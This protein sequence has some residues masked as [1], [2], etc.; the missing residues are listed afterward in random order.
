VRRLS[1]IFIS[2][3]VAIS[4]L[5]FTST[6]ASAAGGTVSVKRSTTVAPA[7]VPN[8]TV[9]R[10]T[11]LA[12]ANSFLAIGYDSQA[13]GAR[14]H[15][16]KIKEDMTLD[17]SFGAVNFGADLALPTA[18]NS[19]CVS[20]NFNS[21]WYLNSVSVNETT[22]RYFFSFNRDVNSSANSM[23]NARLTT[24]VVGKLSTG[25]VIA[26]VTNLEDYGNAYNV[27]DWSAYGATK[28]ANNTCTSLWGA[29]FQSVPLSAAQLE[30]YSALIRS[31]GSAV[32]NLS[33]TYSNMNGSNSS[34]HVKEYRNQALIAVKTSG[35]TLVLDSS[36]GTNGALKLFDDPTKCSDF[37]PA[38]TPDTSITSNSSSKLFATIQ[39]ATG[40]RSNTYQGGG[41][42]PASYDGCGYGMLTNSTTKL[43]AFKADGAVIATT[44][45]NL[46]SSG[47]YINR[48]I[49]DPKGNWNTV[50]RTGMGQS[51]STK[52]LR[53]TPKGELDTTLG[54]DGT[55]TL[56]GL[57]ATISVNGTNVNMFYSISGIAITSNGFYF[58]GFSS[59]GSSGCNN[60]NYTSKTYPYY[61]SPESGL[62]TSYGTNGLGEGLTL[63]LSNTTNCSGSARL[64]YINSKGQHGTVA[65]VPAIGS[66]VAGLVGATWDATS[67]V[68]S[69]GEGS[70][71][72]GAAG[73]VDKKVYSTRLPAATQVDSALTVLTAKQAQDLDIR[74]NTPRI[75]VALTTSVLM[76]NPGRCS[77]RIID[78]DTKKVIRTMTTIVKKSDVAEGTT[79]TTDEPIYFRQANVRLSKNA[80]A[81]VAELAAAAKDAKRVVV[82]G[83]SAALGDVSKYSFA[84]SRNRANAVKAAL[85][86]AGVKA[87]IEIVAMAY[88]QPE[89]T[90]KTEAAQ[91]KNRRAEVY[92]FP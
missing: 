6:V 89:K 64:T 82:I 66:Q 83:H 70:G 84:I 78:E 33:C 80:M 52:L 5:T 18:S 71:V 38:S 35:A 85:V 49:I 44:T 54:S 53:L 45:L 31:D 19:Y 76:V 67:E 48:W 22:D 50:I 65:Q 4:G 61:L 15:M 81:Q 74:T 26:K 10:F 17:S 79:L 28:F 7:A 29:S 36:W 55:K 86:K 68:T 30:S 62:I 8:A 46:G 34:T 43:L 24:L 40:A 47:I 58:T 90:A 91:A 9:I 63:E 1:S 42:Q 2:A 56:T 13:T 20:N 27:S 41:V 60:Q 75:C 69:G 14:L 87:T 32:V 25:E 21:C 23:I 11:R 37:M 39:V 3:A 92:I 16:W 77:V 73:R 12:K 59:T 88:T 57:P 51:S 72:A